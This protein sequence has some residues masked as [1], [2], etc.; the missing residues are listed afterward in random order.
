V[1]ANDFGIKDESNYLNHPSFF[2]CVFVEKI[3]KILKRHELP[4]PIQS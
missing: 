4:L 1:K 3:K 2:V